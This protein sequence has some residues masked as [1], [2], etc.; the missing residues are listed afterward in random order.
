MCMS[1]VAK[2]RVA[3]EDPHD[4][5]VRDREIRCLRMPPRISARGTDGGV[6]CGGDSCCTGDGT[7]E[8]ED[9]RA[10]RS[11]PAAVFWVRV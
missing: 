8:D 9:S 3:A 1:V 10:D 5:C 7:R 4:V 11:S 2:S 6:H